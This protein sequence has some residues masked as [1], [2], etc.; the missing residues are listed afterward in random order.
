MGAVAAGD[1]AVVL[2]YK[3]AG[4]FIVGSSLAEVVYTQL[5]SGLVSGAI[6]IVMREVCAGVVLFAEGEGSS[7]GNDNS[8]G[9]ED[10]FKSFHNKKIT[11][12]HRSGAT[13]KKRALSGLFYAGSLV[14]WGR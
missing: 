13:V 8:Q 2:L 12:I 3:G 5:A 1:K 14:C 9:G 4:V 6:E 10:K 11:G 7:D